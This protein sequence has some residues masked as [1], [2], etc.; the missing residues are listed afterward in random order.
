MP[1]DR[2]TADRIWSLALEAAAQA[3]EAE[4]EEAYIHVMRGSVRFAKSA[5]AARI[6]A[7]EIIAGRRPG[8]D[9]L[10]GNVDIARAA[11]DGPEVAPN[12]WQP[13][14]TAPRDGRE[15]L[16]F[17]PYDEPNEYVGFWG[18][19]ELPQ[20]HPDY[21]AGWSYVDELLIN[22]CIDEPAPT[23]WMPLP[24]PPGSP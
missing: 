12:G 20:G 21:W 15:L 18:W 19:T 7:L 14:E 11:L 6:R 4:P 23:H 22:H 24:E 16:L 8:A 3:A 2:A 13:I 9:N 17:S 10:M 1:T 5:I